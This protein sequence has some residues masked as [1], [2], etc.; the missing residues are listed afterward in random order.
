MSLTHLFVEQ[1]PKRAE[2]VELLKCGTRAAAA[3]DN[4]ITS[5][6][7][8]K[9]AEHE[10]Q[11]EQNAN[12]GLSV[13]EVGNQLEDEEPMGKGEDVN[14]VKPSCLSKSFRRENSV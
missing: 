6:E 4:S 13:T 9:S 7:A 5:D 11:E 3:N 8:N 14:Q 12:Q 2:D 10:I 1:N